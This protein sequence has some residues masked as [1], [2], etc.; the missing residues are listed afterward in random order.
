MA[1]CQIQFQKLLPGSALILNYT[2]RW[3]FSFKFQHIR[4]IYCQLYKFHEKWMN[5]EIALAVKNTLET[6]SQIR[7]ENVNDL[8]DLCK[9]SMVVGPFLSCTISK[10]FEILKSSLDK[11]LD[12]LDFTRETRQKVQKL[13]GSFV[14][15]TYFEFRFRNSQCL[16]G[17]VGEKL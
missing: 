5:R 14:E 16:N 4:A 17:L 6:R 2:T 12:N 15:V 8:T 10:S 9:L 11:T 1:L 13:S 7:T 3:R